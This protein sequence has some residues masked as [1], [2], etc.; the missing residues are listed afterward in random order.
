MVITCPLINIAIIGRTEMR[1]NQLI[2]V[3]IA[4]KQEQAIFELI[5]LIRS[6]PWEKKDELLAGI[7]YDFN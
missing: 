5:S 3:D 2:K 6:R 4:P 7:D 1:E